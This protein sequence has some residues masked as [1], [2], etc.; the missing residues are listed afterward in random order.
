MTEHE[1]RNSSIDIM[2][3]EIGYDDEDDEP[4]YCGHCNEF[5]EVVNCVDDLCHGAGECMH[6]SMIICPECNGTGKL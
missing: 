1:D 4:Q 3:D 5:G 2:V 6:G